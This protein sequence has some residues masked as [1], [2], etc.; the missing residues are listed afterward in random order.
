[1]FAVSESGTWYALDVYSPYSPS[2][3]GTIAAGALAGGLY[4]SPRGPKAAA[5]TAGVG[6]VAAAGLLAL[7]SVFPGV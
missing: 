5:I 6:G 7:R 4:R 3:Y 2:W 1:M